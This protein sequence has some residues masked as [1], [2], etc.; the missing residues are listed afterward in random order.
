MSTQLAA[1]GIDLIEGYGARIRSRSTPDAFVIGNVDH[2][3]QPADGSDP[4]STGCP[5]S[6]GPQ[7]LAENVLRGKCLCSPSPAPTA[8][9]R[10]ATMLAWILEQAGR[11]SRGSSSAASRRILPSPRGSA[12]PARLLRHRGRRVRHGLLR[13]ALEVRALPAAHV[14]LLNNLEF[15]HAD[16]FPDLG[17]DRNAVPPPRAHRCPGQRA[18]SSRTAR[19]IRISSGCSRAGAGRRSCASASPDGWQAGTPGRTPRRA[20]ACA[21]HGESGHGHGCS[22]DAARRAQPV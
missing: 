14:A 5:T 13:Q 1:Q 20:S 17:G 19:T 2:A 6:P 12:A 7:W 16:I 4:R 3:R 22:W 11:A 15:D 10:R 9:P 21:S 18:S 8:R